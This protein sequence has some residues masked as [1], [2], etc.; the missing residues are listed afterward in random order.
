MS[1]C[2]QFWWGEGSH[3]RRAYCVVGWLPADDSTGLA[4]VQSHLSRWGWQSREAGRARVEGEGGKSGKERGT[5]APEFH[6][7]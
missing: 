1:D 6:R 3:V 5:R 2:K 4:G 7:G